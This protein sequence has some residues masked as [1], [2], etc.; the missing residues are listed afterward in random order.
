MSIFAFTRRDG[1]AHFTCTGCGADVHRFG[2]GVFDYPICAECQFI[3][4]HPQLTDEIKALLRG[5]P[6]PPAPETE[7]K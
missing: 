5:E 7:V 2:G 3:G 1:T 6:W 4:E